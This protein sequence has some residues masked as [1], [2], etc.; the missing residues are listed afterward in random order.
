MH[1]SEL[2]PPTTRAPAHAVEALVAE[3]RIDLDRFSG[4]DRNVSRT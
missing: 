1:P 3:T 2:M 4:S